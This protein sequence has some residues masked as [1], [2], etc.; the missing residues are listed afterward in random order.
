MDIVGKSIFLPGTK[1]FQMFK[2]AGSS[3][4]IFMGP[5]ELSWV[6]V[7]AG[8]MHKDPIR[9][10][11]APYFKF[12]GEIFNQVLV[13]W[14]VSANVEFKLIL[15]TLLMSK[16]RLPSRCDVNWNLLDFQIRMKY[17]EDLWEGG[18][19]QTVT[20]LLRRHEMTMQRRALSKHDPIKRGKH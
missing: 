3:D 7:E 9:S 14:R 11:Q 18:V 19:M 10:H 1:I 5:T 12:I 17:A 2:C 13:S 16:L 20:L 6:E 4:C 8:E 15:M